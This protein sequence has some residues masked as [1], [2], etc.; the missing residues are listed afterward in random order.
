MYGV[1]AEIGEAIKE[2]GIP[3]EEIFVTSKFWPHFAPD[4]VELCLDIILKQMG[5]DYID[6]YLAH[7]PYAGKPISQEALLN[8]KTG[9][10]ASTEEKGIL[11]ENGKPV[12]N[13]EYCPANIASLSGI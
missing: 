2:S 10:H 7:W 4:N 8:S 13:W 11:Y 5:L 1:D 6:L 12:I 9:P 3:R